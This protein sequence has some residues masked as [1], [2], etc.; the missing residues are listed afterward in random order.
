MGDHGY[1]GREHCRCITE[2]PILSHDQR[3]RTSEHP[4]ASIQEQ[5][6]AAAGGTCASLTAPG[7]LLIISHPQRSRNSSFVMMHTSMRLRPG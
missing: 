2:A 3:G 4:M 5:V 1:M 7:V 6:R